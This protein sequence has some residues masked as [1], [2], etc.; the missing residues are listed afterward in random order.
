MESGVCAA[1]R[2]D[3]AGL[4]LTATA[5][6][7]AV[8]LLATTLVAIANFAWLQPVFDQLR[9]Y[10]T[11]LSLPFPHSVVQLDNGH[12]P[13]LPAL[14]RVAEI[15]GFGANQYL[16]IV[17]A[18]VC[19]STTVALIAWCGWR[20]RGA[21][22]ARAAAVLAPIVAVFWLANARILMHGTELVHVHLVSLSV[23]VAAL[24]VWH[25][26]SRHSY[27]GIVVAALACTAAMFS[28]GTGVASFAAVLVLI[29][30]LRL[31]RR[32]LLIPLAALAVCLLLYLAVLPG[33]D[34]VRHM[35]A[36]RPLDSLLAGARWLSSPWI[37]G[38]LGLADPPLHDWLAEP[39][40][41][42]RSGAALCVSARLLDGLPG[43]D[44]RTTTS[45]LIGLGGLAVLAMAVIARWRRWDEPTRLETVA[46][47]F[48]LFSAACAGI[49]GLGRLD[50]LHDNPAQLFA[51]RYLIWPCLFWMSLVLL[52]LAR[53]LRRGRGTG[54]ATVLVCLVAAMAL[55]THRA[56]AHWAAVVHAR[57]ERFA[58][59][60]RSGV[61]DAA[62][63][64]PADDADPATV[65]RT[66][67]LLRERR[68][69]MFAKTWLPTG[70]RRDGRI[71]PA[72]DAQVRILSRELVSDA[73]DARPALY[74]RGVVER[75]LLDESG[76]LVFLDADRRIRG[77]AQR[78]FIAPG[79][80][81]LRLDVP[82]KRGFDGYIAGFDPTQIYV[83]VQWSADGRSARE[84][85]R[86]TES[87]Y[88]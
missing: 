57:A 83:L 87:S 6:A 31:P 77:Y 17:F 42:S 52:G 80:S 75:G 35:V 28:F 9:F 86:L 19:A 32:W 11:Y 46:L 2:R 81:S 56:Y 16:Q 37:V 25:A 59:A 14:V 39:V 84:L 1:M 62:T 70:E 63:L 10:E 71:D 67:S 40:C 30:L 47:T 50:Y 60:V 15:T 82:A 43:A 36:L 79:A 66:L 48:G 13:V 7:L 4:L 64:P 76:P 88:E 24:G 55:P 23:A 38:W 41:V 21:T 65:A 8:G 85:L 26:H 45:A 49:I 22:A 33:N 27:R 53:V 29:G 72:G 69:A 12:R 61:V 54:L 58:A 5:F 68:L 74:L 44:W 51:D 3:N 20:E 73:A 34:G 18:V 78:S